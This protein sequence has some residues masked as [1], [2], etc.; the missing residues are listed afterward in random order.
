MAK[1]RRRYPRLSYTLPL[2]VSAD[3]KELVTETKNISANGAYCVINRDVE[4]MTKFQII[5]LVPQA[6]KKQKKKFHKIECTGVV[7]RKEKI[8][9]SDLCGKSVVGV[10]IFFSD[11]TDKDRSLLKSFVKSS[12][13]NKNPS[14]YNI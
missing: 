9:E 13:S 5:M 2:K 6:P 3:E 14:A 11:L 1:E 7:V 8:S 4:L 10:G 12:I